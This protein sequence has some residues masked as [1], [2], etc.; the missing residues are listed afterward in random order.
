MQTI[1]TP[2]YWQEIS[3]HI[4]SPTDGE[5]IG[6]TTKVMTINVQYFQT[7]KAKVNMTVQRAITK[8]QSTERISEQVVVRLVRVND[9]WLVS[10]IE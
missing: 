9:I 2:E 6:V 1:V 3:R 8:G 5:F 10:G 7:N 4:G